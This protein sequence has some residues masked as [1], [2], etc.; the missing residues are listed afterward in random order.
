MKGSHTMK[1]TSFRLLAAAGSIML[2][3]TLSGCGGGSVGSGGNTT[4]GEFL[5]LS[6]D[7]QK[8]VIRDFLK[9]QGNS[10]PS[11]GQVLLYQ[12]SATLY[13]STLGTS[14][15]PIRNING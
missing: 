10:N 13:C 2:A 8:Q 1:K 7:N 14:S 4:C 15:D 6:A 3:A 12:A 11:G 9:E 5:S